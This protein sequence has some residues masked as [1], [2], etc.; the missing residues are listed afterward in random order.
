VLVILHTSLHYEGLVKISETDIPNLWQILNA[1]E[2]NKEFNEV[3]Y[4]Y[5]VAYRPVARQRQQNKQLDN[6]RYQA[7]DRK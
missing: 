6:D 3:D 5:I 2:Q 1:M 7:T 4:I